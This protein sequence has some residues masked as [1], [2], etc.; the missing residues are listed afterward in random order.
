V[1]ALTSE[2]GRRRWR[3]RIP[4]EGW[5]SDGGG[6]QKSNGKG[7]LPVGCFGG[8]TEEG[9]RPRRND[10]ALL[11]RRRGEA[12]EGR[13]GGQGSGGTWIEE[14]HEKGG[15]VLTGGGQRGRRGNG[16]QQ[17]DRGARKRHSMSAQGRCRGR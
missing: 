3:D 11:K 17:P 7:G 2:R 12:Q 9:K 15:L 16:R 1:A 13:G 8:R 14:K 5:R 10:S 4:D 6:G